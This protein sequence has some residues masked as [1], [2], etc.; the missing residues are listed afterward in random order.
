M[1]AATCGKI[2]RPPSAFTN[3]APAAESFFAARGKALSEEMRAALS[4]R[5]LRLLADPELTPFFGPNSRAEVAIFG[6]LKRNDGSPLLVS[7]RIDRLAVHQTHVD[8]VDF[9]LG[10]GARK[11][12]VGQLA[13]YRAAL[14]PIHA[15]PV[16]AWIVWLDSG[17]AEEISSADLD[18]A[19]KERLQ[20]RDAAP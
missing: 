5:V 2:S 7:G 18:D 4:E 15:T 16:R 11:A 13:L 20:T 19:C 8:V 12:Y 14:L 3:S 9:K 6:T 10:A 17:T 1:M